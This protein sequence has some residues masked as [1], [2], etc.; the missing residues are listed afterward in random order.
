MNW[1]VTLGWLPQVATVSQ[2]STFKLFTEIQ[3]RRNS[4]GAGGKIKELRAMEA[5]KKQTNRYQLCLFLHSNNVDL[6]KKA[7]LI[8]NHYEFCRCAS[9]CNKFASS[10]A[11]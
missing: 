8:E 7:E 4:G 1:T 3:G 6:K 5:C 9:S 11:L 10:R 2:S